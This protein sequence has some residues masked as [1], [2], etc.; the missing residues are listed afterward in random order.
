MEKV[1]FHS[2]NDDLQLQHL[3]VI[4]AYCLSSGFH[5]LDKNRPSVPS[6]LSA[7]RLSDE[8]RKL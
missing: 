1:V 6:F 8:A 3:F 5:E 4:I 7:W 2:I